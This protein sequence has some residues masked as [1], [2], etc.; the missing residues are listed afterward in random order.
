MQKFEQSNKGTFAL[1]G[2]REETAVT[3][4]DVVRFLF[5]A[6]GSFCTTKALP[7]RVGDAGGVRNPKGGNAV[8]AMSMMLSESMVTT[9]FGRFCVLVY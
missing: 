1:M 9:G 4:N 7:P 6:G 3:S 5:R 8:E 2:V